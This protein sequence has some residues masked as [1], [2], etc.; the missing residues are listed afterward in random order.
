MGEQRWWSVAVVGTA[1]VLATMLAIVSPTAWQMNVG[2]AAVAVFVAFWF[3][4][5]ARVP[6]GSRGASAVVVVTIAFSGAVTLAFPA[7]AFVQAIAFPLIWTRL[8]STRRAIIGSFV[9]AGTVGVAM[10][11]SAGADLEGLISAAISEVLSIIFAIAFGLWITRIEN[12]STERQNLIDELR[13][14]QHQVAM[15]SQDAGVTSERER[16]ARE[17][18]DTIAQ[19]LTG[20]VLLAQRASRELSAGDT[21]ATAEQLAVLEEG[22][23]SALA[24]TRA[25]VASTAPADLDTGGIA[26]ALERLGQR[27]ERETDLTVTIRVDA[28]PALTRDLEVVLLRCAQEGL[29]NVRKHAGATQASLTLTGSTLELTDN[30]HG[31]DPAS[32]SSGFGLRG[33]RDR[34]ALVG[35]SLEI[36]SSPQGTALRVAL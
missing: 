33:M 24:D 23:R 27:Y 30:G 3:A 28:A 17:I 14:T 22:A 35:G 32:T 7:A 2:L 20:L 12:R 29:A 18:H 15:L 13:A 31:F 6:D 4:V 26:A 9:L 10:F 16:L 19:D 25:L 21:V 11:Y 8:G 5:G 1:A 36:H 34:L